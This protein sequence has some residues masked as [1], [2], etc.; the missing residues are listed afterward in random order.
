MK[1]SFE[2]GLENLQKSYEKRIN[3]KKEPVKDGIYY[4]SSDTRMHV[5]T[6]T[7][8]RLTDYYMNNLSDGYRSAASVITLNDLINKN[9]QLGY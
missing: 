9:K 5:A 3:T 8:E 2:K 7:I 4:A 6:S 1:Y